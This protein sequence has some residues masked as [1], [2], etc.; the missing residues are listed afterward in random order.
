M[1][2]WSV[3]WVLFVALGFRQ[4]TGYKVQIR[5]LVRRAH[6]IHVYAVETLPPPPTARP[7]IASLCMSTHPVHAVTTPREPDGVSFE[8]HMQTEVY[9]P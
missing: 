1:V 2:D 5:R 8:F 6:T 7:R 4:N 3:D 9:E